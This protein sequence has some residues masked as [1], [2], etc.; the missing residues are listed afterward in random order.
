M[1]GI[2][3][4]LNQN[5]GQNGGLFAGLFDQPDTNQ[6]RYLTSPSFFPLRLFGPAT[7]KFDPTMFNLGLA[8]PRPPQFQQAA[9]FNDRSSLTAPPT[10]Y[11]APAQNEL[12]LPGQNAP[13]DDARPLAGQSGLTEYSPKREGWHD[14]T[15]GPSLICPAVLACT[16]EEIA[17][18]L[19]RYA[20]PGQNPSIPAE[21]NGEYDAYDPWAGLPAGRVKTEISP[22]GLTVTNKT[23]PGHILYD[24]KIVRSASQGS[25]GAWYV[26][27]HG[28]GNNVIPGMNVLNEKIGPQIFETMDEKMKDNIARHHS[29]ATASP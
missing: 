17:D 9:Q 18:H 13:Y 23:L 29:K 24:G 26:T 2:L 19:S 20:V 4:T 21:T 16:P 3:D 12:P 1:V 7:A 22:D 27:T 25:D 5:S 8:Q 6:P 15:Q 28:F 14:Y 11:A 10:D